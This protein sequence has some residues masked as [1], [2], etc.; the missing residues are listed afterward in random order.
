MGS[1]LQRLDVSVALLGGREAAC[2]S[3]RKMDARRDSRQLYCWD[4]TCFDILHLN[5]ISNTVML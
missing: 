1:K 4:C 2:L 5:Q 3:A